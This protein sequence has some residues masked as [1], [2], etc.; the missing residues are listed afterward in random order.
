MN[1]QR[2]R[3][4]LTGEVFGLYRVLMEAEYNSARKCSMWRCEC[5]L[6]GKTSVVRVDTLTSGRSNGCLGCVR[7]SAKT[8]EAEC[9]TPVEPVF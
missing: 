4:D 5:V 8:A 2:R 7:K 1:A 6:C 3:V 9:R